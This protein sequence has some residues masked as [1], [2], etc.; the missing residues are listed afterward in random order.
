MLLYEGT[1]PK[2]DIVKLVFTE[3]ENEIT[4][5]GLANLNTYV[6]EMS[7]KFITGMEDIETGWD[8]FQ[9]QLKAMNIEGVLECAQASYDRMAA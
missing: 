4:A 2:E 1:G 5:A 8:D 3:D 7:G 9:N 6:K